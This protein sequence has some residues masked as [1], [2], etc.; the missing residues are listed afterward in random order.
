MQ[1]DH[2]KGCATAR[3]TGI[4]NAS[5][6]YIAFLDDDDLWLPLKI[7]K[8]LELMSE[9]DA[10]C[11]ANRTEGNSSKKGY[12]MRFTGKRGFYEEAGKAQYN[13]IYKHLARKKNCF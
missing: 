5:G 8:Q 10:V 9:Y 1:H 13:G 7:E 3:N 6:E 4:D 12:V 2:N 11:V